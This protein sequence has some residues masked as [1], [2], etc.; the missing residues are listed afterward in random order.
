[1]TALPGTPALRRRAALVL[2]AVGVVLLAQAVQRDWPREQTLIFRLEGGLREI[3]L[4]LDT[5]VTRVGEGEARG[6]MS[7]VRDGTERSN[8]QQTLR[9][10]DGDYV[11]TVAWERATQGGSS[12]NDAARAAKEVETSSVHRV[13]LVGGE[14]VVPVSPR[15]TE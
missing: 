15:V 4:K 1:M 6:G 12:G 13:T 8:P 9:L 7:V 5:S 10:P 14:V 11:V 2:L 3:P